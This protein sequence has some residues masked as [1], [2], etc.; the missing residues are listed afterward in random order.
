[1]PFLF[2]VLSASPQTKSFVL[3]RV[4]A[5][6]ID[7]SVLFL[8][9][10]ILPYPIGPIGGFLYTVFCDGIGFKKFQG[11]SLGKKLLKLQ[12]V[13]QKSGA[14]I[15]WKHSALRNAPVGFATFFAII[16]VWGWLILFLIGLPLM[17]MEVYLILTAAQ[18]HRLGDVMADTEVIELKERAE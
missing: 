18:G 5:K 9:A 1:M 14:P 13:Q 2:S 16:P 3:N 4:A 6:L 15:G 17:M 8:S 11:Q 12:V 10:M 7:I